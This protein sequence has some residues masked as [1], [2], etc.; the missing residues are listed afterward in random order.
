MQFKSYWTWL[1]PKKYSWALNC[2]AIFDLGI[3]NITVN[4]IQLLFLV[5]KLPSISNAC[6]DRISICLLKLF[7][8]TITT[9]I[10]LMII[11]IAVW[12]NL[13]L[14]WSC[15]CIEL[16]V[17]SCVKV[18]VGTYLIHRIRSLNLLKLQPFNFL[19]KKRNWNKMSNKMQS[20]NVVYILIV[21][22]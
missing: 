14:Q 18:F 19:G 4:V 10:W 20:V 11:N 1:R 9:W 5:F 2:A 22:A 7:K 8:T 21:A 3:Q 15:R 13:V 17:M 6:A 12:N 16:F